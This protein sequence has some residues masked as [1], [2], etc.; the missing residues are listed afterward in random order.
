[1]KIVY[2]SA[3]FNALFWT[4]VAFHSAVLL[5]CSL[6]C[7]NNLYIFFVYVS[8]LVTKLCFWANIFDKV[9]IKKDN[10]WLFII[11][12]KTRTLAKNSKIHIMEKLPHYDFGLPEFDGMDFDREMKN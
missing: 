12:S 1:M 3:L 2:C 5:V 7:L 4:P 9:N 8:P 10:S 11:F 6:F